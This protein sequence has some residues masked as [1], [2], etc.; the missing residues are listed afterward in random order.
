MSL[1]LLNYSTFID[2]QSFALVQN[3][4]LVKSLEYYRCKNSDRDR[5]IMCECD[6]GIMVTAKK[7][8]KFR[9]QL[10]K[11]ARKRAERRIETLEEEK[12]QKMV[13]RITGTLL[14]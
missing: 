1:S 9:V 14:L 6:S 11:K 13:R 7:R 3:W 12:Q 10:L 5:C 2:N 8:Q 4:L